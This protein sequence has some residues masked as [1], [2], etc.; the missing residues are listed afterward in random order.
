MRAGA[1]ALVVLAAARAAAAED[2]R[3]DVRIQRRF[4]E[5]KHRFA[6][7]A[8][9]AYLGRGDFYRSP[10]VEA[11]LSFYPIERLAIDLRGAWFFTYP[12]DELREVTSRTGFLP[13]SR[14][15]KA[16][17]LIGAR[18]SLGYAKLRVTSKWVLHFEPQLFLY[19]GIHVTS[20]A[21]SPTAVAPMG[22]IGLG[23]LLY[24]TS[25]IQVRLDAGLTVGGEQRT[26][27]VV[28]VGGYPTVSAGFLF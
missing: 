17:V 4:V 8:G 18:Y 13:D 19:G 27:Y 5:Q 12:S 22:E 6:L 24:A 16:S 2:L 25:H 7:Y 10:G 15:S 14:P 9:F 1:I 26:S 21:Q 20:G 11:A 28:V 23:F 3:P